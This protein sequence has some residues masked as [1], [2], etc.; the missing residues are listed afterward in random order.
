MRR[1]FA[2]SLT[3]AA[4]WLMLALEGSASANCLHG[5]LHCKSCS[6]YYGQ[7]R[8]PAYAGPVRRLRVTRISRLC[9]PGLS[10]LCHS[11][12]SWLCHSRISRLFHPGLSRLRH[13]RI[14]RLF[15]PGLSRLCYSRV[16]RLLVARVCS[17]GTAKVQCSGGRS[18]FLLDGF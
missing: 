10:R 9:H 17:C 6:S 2:T 8:S 12:V 11:R 13:S 3:L 7:Y 5:L 4:V 18:D 1:P 14:S 16:S 15:H